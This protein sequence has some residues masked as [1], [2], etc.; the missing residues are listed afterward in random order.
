[1]CELSKNALFHEKSI[2]F[3]SIY[4]T[5]LIFTC[6]VKSII[7]IELQ[8]WSELFQLCLLHYCVDLNFVIILKN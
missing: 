3:I 1:V 2:N 7:H 8:S 5:L 4:F 6:G